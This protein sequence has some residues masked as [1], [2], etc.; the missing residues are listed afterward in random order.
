MERA[1]AAEPE[2]E[3]QPEPEPVAQ[4]EP[5]PREQAPAAETQPARTVARTPE[6][7]RPPPPAVPSRVSARV[8]GLSSQGSLPTS[9]VSRA[10]ER[11]SGRFQGCYL[12]AARRAR[13]GGADRVQV[14][15]EIDEM[16]RARRVSVGGGSLPGLSRCVGSAVQQVV[17]RR[18]PDIGTVQASFAVVF[19]P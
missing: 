1:A 4:P 9:V 2:P 10:I 5:P 14:R 19:Q 18:R 6:P 8:T 15:F 17:S 13:R 3:P 7:P 12:D 11:V 16:G